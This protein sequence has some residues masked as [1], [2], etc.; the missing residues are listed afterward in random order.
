MFLAL[1][2]IRQLEDDEV[3]GDHLPEDEDHHEKLTTIII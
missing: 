1:L 2:Q 3:E